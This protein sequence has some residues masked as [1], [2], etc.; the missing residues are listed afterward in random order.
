MASV[1]QE[2]TLVFFQAG[3]EDA[4]RLLHINQ[5]SSTFLPLTENAKA[6][7]AIAIKLTSQE[8]YNLDQIAKSLGLTT[9][10][11]KANRSA[12]LRY[13]SNGS[14]YRD[15]VTS[16][17]KCRELRTKNHELT[18][19]NVELRQKVRVL[20]GSARRGRPTGFIIS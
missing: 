16:D 2:P 14:S 18:R 15:V 3:E 9:A 12:A 17:A 20:R 19:T 6:D 10:T 1:T 7:I 8:A 5:V 4:A 11:G 13:F